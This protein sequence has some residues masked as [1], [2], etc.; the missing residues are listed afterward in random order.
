MTSPA[1]GFLHRGTIVALD[2]MSGGY[3]VRIS[4]LA[5][6]RI[7]GPFPAMAA[8][9]DPGDRVAL[10]S[11]GTSRDDLVIVGKL[12][13]EP[14]GFDLGAWLADY[15][16]RMST[17]QPY[18]EP[19]ALEAANG[20][21]GV[22]RLGLAGAD[23]ASLL[24]PLGYTVVADVDSVTKRPFALAYNEA[25]TDRAWGAF[26]VDLSEP[27]RLMVQAPHPVAD[28]YSELM[29]LDHWR[30][31]PGAILLMAGAHRDATGVQQGGYAIA[32]VC[33][34]VGSMF[35]QVATTYAARNVPGVQW[36]GFA[37]ASA[38]GLDKIVATGS[39]NAGPSSV[40]VAE[41]LADAGF[42]VGRGWDSSGSG[43][44]LIGLTNVHGDDMLARGVAWTHVE[45]NFTTRADPL[46]RTRAVDAVVAAQPEVAGVARMLAEA[47][48]GQFPK[49]V[50]SANTTGTSPYSARA[51]H[52]HASRQ[53]DLDRITAV[54]TKNTSQDTRLT[55]LEGKIVLAVSSAAARP[56]TGLY[57][58]MTIYRTDKGFHEV[59]LP[60]P[61]QWRIPYQATVAALTDVEFPYADQ[62]VLLTTDRMIYRYVAATGWIG[63]QHTSTSDTGHAHYY[64]G[65]NQTNIPSGSSTKMTFGTSSANTADVT[66]QSGNA[67]FVLNRAG[68]WVI[69]ASVAWAGGPGQTFRNLAL[70]DSA[71]TTSY[72][73]DGGYNNGAGLNLSLS[74]THRFAAGTSL[75]LTLYHELGSPLSTAQAGQ[76]NH[77]SF[78]WLRP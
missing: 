46:L 59:Y 28:Q 14:V 23:A 71:I 19:T 64:Q 53:A 27:V 30:K 17:T 9:L 62:R 44:G 20:V 40:R 26:L 42:A 16:S 63:V 58:G 56:T 68:V 32:D 38:P 72:A 3:T 25:G 5:P 75:A 37:D 77:V 70:F 51:D 1:Y 60:G 41:E 74:L 22:E 54:E 73:E 48:S 8:G 52:I 29:A 78:T 6:G 18:R 4:A 57:D 45:N 21:L 34:Q 65:G 7:M 66:R 67:D 49:P 50:G 24:G 12:P 2:P 13:G 47:K 55:S 69:E 43:T 35:H 39:G 33:K 15:A 76:R 36:H 10:A 61:Q 11:I 31:T